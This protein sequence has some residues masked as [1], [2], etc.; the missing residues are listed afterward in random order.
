RLHRD[1]VGRRRG[2]IGRKAYLNH[3]LEQEERRSL[4]YELMEPMRPVEGRR[5]EDRRPCQWWVLTTCT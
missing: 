1:E 2:D 3:P 5:F 4:V